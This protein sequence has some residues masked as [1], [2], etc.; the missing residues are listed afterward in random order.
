MA[1]L[2]MA[3]LPGLVHY[4]FLNFVRHVDSHFVYIVG[5]QRRKGGRTR[6][7]FG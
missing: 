3:R 7:L 2:S 5:L 4:G 6:L 1:Y